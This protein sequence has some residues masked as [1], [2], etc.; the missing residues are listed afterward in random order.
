MVL[1]AVLQPV[2]LA[3][4]ANQDAGRSTVAG[5]QDLLLS[6]HAQIPRQVILYFR[7][8]YGPGPAGRAR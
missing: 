6:R 1:Q 8:G 3:L 7:Q 2:V 4:K 5:N